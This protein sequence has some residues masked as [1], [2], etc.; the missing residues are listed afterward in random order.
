MGKLDG[1]KVKIAR[2][3]R[4]IQELDAAARAYLASAPFAL[5]CV[6]LPN[7]DLLWR[8]KIRDAVPIEWSAIIGDAVHNLRSAL[9]L[10]AWQLVDA[11]GAI[12]SQG[13]CF[14]VTRSG[15]NHFTELRRRALKGA[16][17][18]AVRFVARLKPFGGGNEILVQLHALDI[19]DKHRLTLVVGSA[20]K[21]LV[22]KMKMVVPWQDNPVEFPPI[23]INPADRQFPL[24]DGAEVFRICAAARRSEDRTEFSPVFELA[25]GSVEEVKGLPL[26]ETLQSMHRHVSRIVKIADEHF[27][28]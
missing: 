5:D 22:M 23:A 3:A 6:E 7:G 13:T 21:H 8:V 17:T 4:H 27:F 9:D 28:G 14:P 20:Y 12:P 25:F 16:E 11:N 10:L 2:A 19:S 18:R 15:P 24:R 1:A 26:V